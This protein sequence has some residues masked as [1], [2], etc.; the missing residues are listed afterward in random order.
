M[1]KEYSSTPMGAFP[2]KIRFTAQDEIMPVGTW[3]VGTKTKETLGKQF[4]DEKGNL[5]PANKMFTFAVHDA[6][7]DLHIE[8][9]NGEE[10]QKFPLDED[11]LA[12]LNGNTML[13]DK[14]GQVPVGTRI[15]V[16]Y[17]GK[18][19]GTRMNNYKV[20]DAEVA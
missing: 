20:E 5:K 8:K 1:G 17:L 19:K 16:T 14:L 7:D 10:W 3:F 13:D 11:G 12:E 9:K 18:K 2:P 6:S 15:K 4:K